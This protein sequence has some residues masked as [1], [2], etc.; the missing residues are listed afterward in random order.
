MSDFERVSAAG[1][2]V[3]CSVCQGDVFERRSMTLVTS[4]LANS[5]FDKSGQLAVCA[6]CGDVH[7][8]F[9]GSPLTWGK[10]ERHRA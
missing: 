3:I 9:Q 10:A 5:G 7:I 8:F 4:G 6:T 2:Q 1:H